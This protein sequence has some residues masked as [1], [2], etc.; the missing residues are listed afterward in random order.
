MKRLVLNL[1]EK[2]S[3]NLHLSYEWNDSKPIEGEEKQ[4]QEEFKKSV[5]EYFEKINKDDL[6]YIEEIWKEEEILPIESKIDLL[7]KIDMDTVL[8]IDELKQVIVKIIDAL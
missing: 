7:K 6:F 2:K 5:L 4:S 1:I 3:G 8:N